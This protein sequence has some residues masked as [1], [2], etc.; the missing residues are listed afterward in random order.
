MDLGNHREL[1]QQGCRLTP[2]RRW[3]VDDACKSR[4]PA[5]MSRSATPCAVAHHRDLTACIGKY[6]ERGGRRRR[7]GQPR[8][9]RFPDRLRDAPCLRPAARQ[10]RPWR[11][12][13]RRFRPAL[14]KIERRIRRYKRRLKNHHRPGIK[15]TDE[16]AALYVLMAPEAEDENEE[17]GW[18]SFAADSSGHEPPA[19][20]VIAETQAKIKTMTVSMAV[21]ELDL[22]E[23]K[24]LCSGMPPTAGSPWYIAG[25]M[26]IS[27]GSTRSGPSRLPSP[28]LRRRTN[29]DGLRSFM[30]MGTCQSDGLGAT[31]SGAAGVEWISV[32]CWIAMRSSRG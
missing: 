19:G 23:F 10:P 15:Q 8:R 2:F 14:G 30:R 9:P 5:S 25:R 1:A 13:P 3:R 28:A 24:Q 27:A 12:R 20:V 17:G 22:T 6:F 18:D 7:C 11:R 29:L 32:T 4:Y 31:V 26:A 21:M 16:T